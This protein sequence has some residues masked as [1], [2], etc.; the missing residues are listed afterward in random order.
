MA[1]YSYIEGNPVPDQ[2]RQETRPVLLYHYAGNT[3]PRGSP[4][5]AGVNIAN[6][7]LVELSADDSGLKACTPRGDPWVRPTPPRTRVPIDTVVFQYVPA[8]HNKFQILLEK[9]M[10]ACDEAALAVTFRKVFVTFSDVFVTY[11]TPCKAFY[12]SQ[13]SH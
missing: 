3:L 2:E 5:A 12:I 9:N 11:K 1:A 8:P 7:S 6:R 4:A 10:G 13:K